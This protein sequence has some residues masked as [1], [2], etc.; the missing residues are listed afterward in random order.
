MYCRLIKASWWNKGG[1]RDRKG[2]RRVDSSIYKKYLSFCTIFFGEQ[3]T[4]DH[5]SY[6]DA[7]CGIHY[8]LWHLFVSLGSSYNWVWWE[9]NT[10]CTLTHFFYSITPLFPAV[11]NLLCMV[12][13]LFPLEI[14]LTKGSEKIDVKSRSCVL[15]YFKF[16]AKSAKTIDSEV[17]AYCEAYCIEF[18]QLIL[19]KLDKDEIPM[20]PYQCCCFRPVVHRNKWI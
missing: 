18:I 16:S 12:I 11:P 2:N 7:P 4:S 20:T 19:M 6:T 10:L 8:F 17:Y 1:G 15:G 5:K 13:G 14:W 3:L 9:G